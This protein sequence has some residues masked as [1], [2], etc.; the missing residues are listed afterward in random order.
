MDYKSVFK[1]AFVF[2]AAMLCLNSSDTS[3]SGIFPEEHY[4]LP[5]N[6]SILVLPL[7]K[8]FND[9]VWSFSD[10]NIALLDNKGV[11]TGI[12]Q[13]QGTIKAKNIKNGQISSCSITVT[14]EEPVKSVYSLPNQP[15]VNSK[16]SMC[17]VTNKN[18]DNLKFELLRQKDNPFQLAAT[19]SEISTDTYLWTAP[20]FLDKTGKYLIRTLYSSGNGW[21]FPKNAE[22]TALLSSENKVNCPSSEARVASDKCIDFIASCEGF[23]S[24]AAPDYKNTL[25]I[26]FGH[27]IEPFVPFSNNILRQEALAMLMHDVNNSYYGK[28][29]NNFLVNNNV[30][31][32]QQQFDALLSFTYNI[33][34]GWIVGNS[35]LKNLILN[36]NGQNN[37]PMGR[38]ES[39]NGLNLRSEPSIKSR[40]IGAL[41]YG[42]TVR[43]LNS[44]GSW[45]LVR[46][47]GGKTGYCY[48]EF[49]KYYIQSGG[50]PKKLDE[51]N[52]EKF[53]EVFSAYHN[54]GGKRSTGLLS[55][56]FHELDMFFKGKY[57]KFN[58]TYYKNAGYK[59]PMGFNK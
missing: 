37:I 21:C 18:V 52:K 56:R 42:E 46:T 32:N 10:K 4:F 49:V 7:G 11:I 3:A 30:F 55:R 44:G 54:A 40:K 26:G 17:A 2:S 51:I 16:F 13:G 34:I 39:K 43:I 14:A 8:I 27:T 25:F 1:T 23:T 28:V 22:T 41:N 6:K 20:I 36:I 35:E 19:K 5:K 38:V 12:R 31:F 33:G 58:H 48:G 50:Q 9:F 15:V 47:S 29:L 45:Y 53:I 59:I 24:K 57:S